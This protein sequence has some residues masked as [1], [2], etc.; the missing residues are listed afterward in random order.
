M[1]DKVAMKIHKLI[2]KKI[3]GD[4]WDFKQEWHKDNERLLHDI[5]CLANTIH[6]RDCYL[7]VGVSDEGEILGV[8]GENRFKQADILD[9]LSNT[10]F[11]GDNVPE[12]KVDTIM[13]NKKA[14]DILTV[15][16]SY[17]V[18]FYLK[19]KS[20]KYQSIKEGF[21]YTRIGDKNTPINQNANIQQI[22]WL[23]KKRLGLTQPPLTQIVNRL[24]SKIEWIENN[25]TY[26]NI[27][28]PEFTLIEEYDDDEYER[29]SG[30][31]YVYS[32]TNS[33]FMY[34]D[35]KIMSHQTVLD[36]FQLVVL[37]SGRYK[38]PIPELGFVGSNRHRGDCKYPYRYY[39]KNS[40]A[41][42]LQQF[43]FD[44]DV[45][46]EVYAKKDFDEVV[47]YF[48]NEEELSSFEAYVESNLATIENYIS[49]A[50]KVHFSVDTSNERETKII[51]YRLSVSLAL[52]KALQDFKQQ[53]IL[54]TSL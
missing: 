10:V 15:F 16:N 24:E 43:F 11:A 28:K 51:K 54:P 46:E 6:D 49:S 20:K 42:K 9:L 31:Y 25:G 37:D 34:K 40:T 36:S 17:K 50:E 44:D 1:E 21:I 22:E 14:I 52:N 48:E 38:T 27:Y 26:H 45:M 32:Q 2:S 4:Y 47:L 19:T 41:Y 7:I 3:E 29:R 13:I 8:N 33:K 53:S 12:L 5:L 35:L 18:P 23:W 39:L 30:E